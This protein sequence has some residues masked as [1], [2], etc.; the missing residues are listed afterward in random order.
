MFSLV[1]KQL[2]DSDVQPNEKK[3][4]NDSSSKGKGSIVRQPKIE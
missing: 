4:D 1:V 3:K 2:I